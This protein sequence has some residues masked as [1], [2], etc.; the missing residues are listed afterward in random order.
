MDPS[1][2]EGQKLFLK[3]TEAL[4]DTKKVSVTQDK[5]TKFLEQVRTDSSKFGWG[6]LVHHLR[7]GT[8]DGDPVW[9]SIIRDHREVTLEDVQRVAL[10]TWGRKNA[11]W[12]ANVPNVLDFDVQ[13]IDPS[14]TPGDIPIFHR[15]V[16]ATMI[17]KRLQGTITAASW[18]ALT[19]QKKQFQWMNAIGEYEND[20]PTMLFLLIK[21]INPDTRVIEE[22]VY[23][24]TRYSSNCRSSSIKCSTISTKLKCKYQ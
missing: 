15:R 24:R 7:T 4:E 11:A 16:R 23:Y 9:K 18:N 5:V 6:E 17:A 2:V 10:K 12:N 13:D 8:K 20:G 22:S 14:R 19:N 21:S 1:T 3:A